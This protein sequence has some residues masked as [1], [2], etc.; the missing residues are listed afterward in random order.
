MDQA[1]A[2]LE[3]NKTSIREKDKMI[4]DLTQQLKEANDVLEGQEK[5]KLIG[6]ILPRSTFKMDELT[7]KS[8]EELQHI[9]ATL[10]QAMPPRVNS[11]RI[12]VT[13]ADLSDREKGLTVGDMSYATKMKRKAK[14]GN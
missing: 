9:R 2:Q 4:G 14:E 12:G 3:E 13:G 10:E 8:L 5:A 6:E 11:A 7:G 1:L